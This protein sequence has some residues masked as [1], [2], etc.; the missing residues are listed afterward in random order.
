MS[1]SERLTSVSPDLL[2]GINPVAAA[3]RHDAERVT[4]LLIVGRG[5]RVSELVVLAEGSGIE[6]VEVS[7][8]ELDR[9]S[10]GARH[11]GVAALYRATPALDERALLKLV[12]ELDRA[13]LLLVLDGVTDPHNLGACLRSADAAGVD[14]VVLPKDRAA[15]VTP[16][17]RK[18]ASGAADRV[19]V[20]RVVNLA[21]TLSTLKE[22]GIWVAGAADSA[23]QNLWASDLKGPLALVLG[24]EGTGL[25]RLTRERCDFLLQIPMRGSVSSLNVSVACGVLLFEALR[26]RSDC[27]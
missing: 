7:G 21:R 23:Q 19:A 5:R 8:E 14:A 17:V 27:P 11:Q 25:R 22:R 10:G 15:D 1:M 3:L 4:Q 2:V 12:D 18:V 16:V 20:A 13:P 6:I 24:S 9:R 26:Q